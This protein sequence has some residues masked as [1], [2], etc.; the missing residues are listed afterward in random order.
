MGE[1]GKK[2]YE[3]QNK[4]VIN[5]QPLKFG[6]EEVEYFLGGGGATETHPHYYTLFFRR[7][8]AREY[9]FCLHPT[10]FAIWIIIIQ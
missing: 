8:Y 2:L 4:V 9:F 1:Y 10:L 6:V 7:N 3:L 5:V